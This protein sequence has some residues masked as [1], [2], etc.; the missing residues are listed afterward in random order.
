MI[1]VTA[2]DDRTVFI[3]LTEQDVNTMR[4]GR[5]VFVDERGTKGAKFSRVILSVHKNKEE[6]I[7]LIRKSGNKVDGDTLI[8]PDPK[9][10][11]GKCSGCEGI[12]PQALLLNGKC[13]ACW[14]ESSDHYRQ[15][16]VSLWGKK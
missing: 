12:M 5:T 1:F 3:M 11:E 13:I 14:K 9:E 8:G 6:A 16:C 7:D 2:K 15:E 4:S 10:A